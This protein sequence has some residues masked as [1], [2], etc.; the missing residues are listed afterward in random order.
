MTRLVKGDAALLIGSHYLGLLLQSAYNSIY[1]IKKILLANRLLVV[2]GCDEGCLVADIRNICTREA[3]SLACQQIYIHGLVNLDR[4]EV[5][6]EDG[7]ALV[8]ARKIY[9][10]FSIETACTEQGTVEHVHTVGSSQDNHTSVGAE[11]VHLGEKG[12]ERVLS[13]IVST[14]GW[15]LA[16]GTA[17]GVNLID[18][19]DARRFLLCL[20]EEV[21]DTRCTY[22]DKHFHE[23]GT[24]HRE[25][26]YTS[27]ASH[28]LRQ[29]SL[30]GSRRTY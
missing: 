30:S 17:H 26:R 28:R 24:A 21:A 12:V 1:G 13:L 3:W 11:T 6:Q 7:L 4:L 19:D 8:Q 10:D 5:N 15:V 18:E 23:V 9:V 20:A 29:K 2:A 16:A 14:H 25:E 22:A 27:F